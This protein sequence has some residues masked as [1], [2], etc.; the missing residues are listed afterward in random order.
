MPLDDDDL[1]S[2]GEANVGAEDVPLPKY[3]APIAK[4][5]SLGLMDETPLHEY[6]TITPAAEHTPFPTM[7][8]GGTIDSPVKKF[9]VGDAMALGAELTLGEI[10]GSAVLRSLSRLLRPVVK[11]VAKVAVKAADELTFK[12]ITGARNIGVGIKRFKAA[13]SDEQLVR[14]AYR[15]NS[16][17]ALETAIT[18]KDLISRVKRIRSSMAA[19]RIYPAAPK[20]TPN[21]YGGF[22]T[23]TDEQLWHLKHRYG[24]EFG[25]SVEHLLRNSFD[26]D[27]APVT[28]AEFMDYF[29]AK[30]IS[31]DMVEYINHYIT[32]FDRPGITFDELGMAIYDDAI[33]LRRDNMIK[34]TQ[35]NRW[36][37]PSELVGEFESWQRDLATLAD[38]FGELNTAHDLRRKEIINRKPR[39]RKGLESPDTPA[40]ELYEQTANDYLKLAREQEGFRTFNTNRLRKRHDE[41]QEK[42]SEHLTNSELLTQNEIMLLDT[43][44]RAST[45]F[46]EASQTYYN[47]FLDFKRRRK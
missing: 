28:I 2:L 8:F 31:E 39:E 12:V 5:A 17:P 21:Q 1:L 7:D 22:P 4:G 18:N 10:T 3:L 41:L 13:L 46:E 38:D 15:G 27:V 16:A 43:I 19:D 45:G 24:N 11:P 14:V 32:S 6:A 34:A 9:D 35:M 20:K 40:M 33:I 29:K 44:D 42:F 25:E 47:H 36:E 26:D 23:R 37:V 30:N